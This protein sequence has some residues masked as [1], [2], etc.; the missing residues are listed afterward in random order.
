MDTI[1]IQQGLPCRIIQFQHRKVS[2]L[3]NKTWKR[4]PLTKSLFN[5]ACPVE[6][7]GAVDF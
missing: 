6:E 7:L 5:R 4:R 1:T 3:E 2:N